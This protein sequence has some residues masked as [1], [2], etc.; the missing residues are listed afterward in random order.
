MEHVNM[1][2]WLSN[3]KLLSFV[4]R[5]TSRETIRGVWQA[6]SHKSG[7]L[8]S[9]LASGTSTHPKDARDLTTK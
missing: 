7:S 4:N 6:S 9:V 1:P 5:E 2:G 3:W 8:V